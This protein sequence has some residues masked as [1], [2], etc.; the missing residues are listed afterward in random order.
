MCSLPSSISVTKEEKFGEP[1]KIIVKNITV[2]MKWQELPK[3]KQT[4][5]QTR[6]QKGGGKE[7]DGEGH[8]SGTQSLVEDSPPSTGTMKVLRC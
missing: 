7:S 5:K 6:R 3:Q 8:Y 2:V 1:V 4:S